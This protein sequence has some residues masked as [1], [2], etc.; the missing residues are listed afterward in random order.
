MV[1]G[2]FAVFIARNMGVSKIPR[3]NI[4]TTVRSDDAPPASPVCADSGRVGSRATV[5]FSSAE[6][7]RVPKRNARY[8]MTAV[9]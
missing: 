7:L 5:L 9:E 1:R 6:V 3:L 8:R 2:Q 4:I